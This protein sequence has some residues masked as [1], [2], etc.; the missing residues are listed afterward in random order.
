MK[1]LFYLTPILRVRVTYIHEKY[2]ELFRSIHRVIE[3]FIIL[4]FL[5]T[6][7]R[8]CFLVKLHV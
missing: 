1:R 6:T 7:C 2:V 3:A 5:T 8:S 4:Y